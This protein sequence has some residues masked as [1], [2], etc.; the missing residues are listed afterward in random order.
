MQVVVAGLDWVR[1]ARGRRR[2]WR[3]DRVDWVAIGVGINVHRPAG[4]ERASALG[5]VRDR[6]E[7]LG[8]LV[9]ALRATSAMRGVLADAELAEFSRRDLA[10]GR[11]CSEPALGVVEGID[12][13]GAL[14]VRTPAGVVECRAGSLVLEVDG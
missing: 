4:V 5:R 3:D 11:R 2:V 13:R 10:R 12:H 1:S 7:V 6:C 9:P 14:V 8:E